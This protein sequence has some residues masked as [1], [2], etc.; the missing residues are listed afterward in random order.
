MDRLQRQRRQ[1]PFLRPQGKKRRRP[2]GRRHQR[3]ARRSR[4]LHRR[5]T[6]G[7]LLQGSA[8]HGRKRLRRVEC[9][10]HR[11]PEGRRR[12]PPRSSLFALP[13]AA[14]AGRN[15][16]QIHAGIIPDLCFCKETRSPV[17]Y[18]PARPQHIGYG[19]PSARVSFW[20]Q[21]RPFASER[22]PAGVDWVQSYTP[23]TEPTM[24]KLL[25]RL[26]LSVLGTVATLLWWTYHDKGSS[27]SAQ[28]MSHIPAR[29]ADGGNQ[30]TIEV[31][32]STPST[33]RVDFQDLSKPT[34][35]QILLN[36]WEKVPPGAHSWLVDIP[37]DIGGYIE[38]EADHPNPGDTLTQRVKI[39]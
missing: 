9:R 14:S 30:L 35:H 19:K 20:K 18:E 21:R 22:P 24:K 5:C 10:Q 33:L 7:R 37:N 38:F 39:N 31:E 16:P 34:G 3:H 13:H 23:L 2:D 36:A 8:E 12:S 6:A 1:R 15:L 11:R 17:R 29:V 4:G 28:S 32:G 26:G 27:S 25:L